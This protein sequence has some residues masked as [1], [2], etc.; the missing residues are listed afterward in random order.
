[1]VHEIGHGIGLGHSRERA[2]VMYWSGGGADLRELDPD[3]VRG[4]TFLYG[5]G[6]GQGLLCD[7]CLSNA[8]CANGGVCVGLE[9]TLAFC[10]VPCGRNFA[11]PEGT[12]CYGLQDSDESQCF[13]ETQFCSDDGGGGIGAGEYCWGAA[14]CANGLECVAIPDGEAQC[15]GSCQDDGDCPNGQRCFG[16]EAN[17]PGLCLGGGEGAFGDPCESDLD[18]AEVLCLPISDTLSVCAAECDPA[19]SACE[20]G[21]SCIAVDDIPG[22]EGICVPPGDV[23]EGGACGGDDR[24]GPDLT[25]ILETDDAGACRAA[26]DPFGDCARNRGCTPFGDDQWFCLPTA[27]LPTEG[28]PCDDGQCGGGLACLEVSDGDERCFRL[29]PDDDPDAPCGQD[30]GCLDIDGN[31]GNLGICSFGEANFGDA[32]ERAAECA[33]FTCVTTDDGGA[34]SRECDTADNACPEGWECLRS[35]SGRLCFPTDEPANN[36]SNNANNA[37]NTNN[38]SN[39]ANNTNNSTNNENNSTNNENNSTNNENNS[40]NNSENNSSNN[41]ENNSSNN[42][43]DNSSNNNA[44][45]ANNTSDDNNGAGGAGGSS[46]GCQTAPASPSGLGWLAFAALWLARRRRAPRAQEVSR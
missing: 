25:C 37:N 18:C 9:P 45:N 44:N 43:E 24:C 35:Q 7:T 19:R 38:S 28:E 32:C 12:A 40:S 13:P 39:N 26:C 33:S 4:V 8:D 20:V 1:M 42:S 3:D 14:Q 17:R 36:S 10:G 46:G 27:N 5:N 41:S 34:C 15:A 22:L 31:D 16:A 30:V 6:A 11:C 2:A 29:C 23:D 21:G